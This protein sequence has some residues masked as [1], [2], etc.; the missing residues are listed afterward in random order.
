MDCQ[1]GDKDQEKDSG[2]REEE[3]RRSN[4]WLRFSGGVL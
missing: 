2:K 4:A 3:D 1:V